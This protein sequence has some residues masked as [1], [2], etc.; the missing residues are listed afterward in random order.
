MAASWGGETGVDKHSSRK[1][2]AVGVVLLIVAAVVVSLVGFGPAAS[3][4][5]S[6][7]RLAAAWDLAQRAGSYRFTSDVEQTTTPSASILNA[8]RSSRVDRLHL[9]G[10]ANVADAAM[11]FRVWS[12]GGSVLS[13]SDS[14]AI[15]VEDGKT[16]QR[17]GTGEWDQ[18]SDFSQM[19]APEGD[20]MSYLVAA[21]DITELGTETRGPLAITRYRFELDGPTL[22]TSMTENLEQAMRQRGELP[23]GATLE[24]PQFYNE[25][26]GTGELWVDDRGYPVRQMLS[27]QFP[28]QDDEIVSAEITVDFSEFGMLDGSASGGWWQ[29]GLELLPGDSPPHAAAW[30]LAFAMGVSA[31]VFVARRSPWAPVRPLTVVIVM[32]LVA[33]PFSEPAVGAAGSRTLT[34]RA[35]AVDDESERQRQMAELAHAIEA[36]REG[37]LPDPHQSRLAVG[38]S[39]TSTR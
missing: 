2:T 16:Y 22:A 35:D 19:I 7:D 26:I 23:A 10:L 6:G 38:D 20:F 32:S 9:Q 4:T 17:V 39:N 31:V 15:R 14:L 24:S 8:G 11:E 34:G 21:R 25:L 29:R 3:S 5:T 37:A 28:E 13:E 27:L 1:A 18:T 12:G 30:L 33:G 36:E